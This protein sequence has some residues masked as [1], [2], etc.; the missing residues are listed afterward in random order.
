VT[1][2]DDR[3]CVFGFV[4]SLFR[5]QTFT[6]YLAFRRSPLAGLTGSAVAFWPREFG[7]TLVVASTGSQQGDAGVTMECRCGTSEKSTRE[8]SRRSCTA[9]GWSHGTETL[10]NSADVGQ[11]FLPGRQSLS[12]EHIQTSFARFRRGAAEFEISGRNQCP[13][14]QQQRS[15]R[16]GIRQTCQ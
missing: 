15:S 3:A 2:A 14:L 12:S 6:H 11:R 7:A 1:A 13:E 16:F 5:L 10:L 4:R 9:G 8:M